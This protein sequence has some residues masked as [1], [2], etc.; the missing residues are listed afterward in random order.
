MEFSFVGHTAKL[1]PTLVILIEG[2]RLFQ[3]FSSH[4]NSHAMPQPFTSNKTAPLAIIRS[5]YTRKRR[6]VEEY[7]AV[8]TQN[9]DS[10]TANNNQ[11]ATI[12]G[13]LW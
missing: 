5:W 13:N 7:V 8:A 1:Q 11:T 2:L 6:K 9:C 4:L 12:F 3:V 10:K